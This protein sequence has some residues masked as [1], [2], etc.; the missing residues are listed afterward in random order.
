[1]EVICI[2]ATFSPE[3]ELYFKTW[4]IT[5]P[6]VDKIYTIREIV[7]NTVGEKGLLLAS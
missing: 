7:H 4:G 1:M 5:K 2:N 3:W 6:M